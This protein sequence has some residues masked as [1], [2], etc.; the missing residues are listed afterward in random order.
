LKINSVPL[1][2]YLISQPDHDAQREGIKLG[3]FLLINQNKDAQKAFYQSFTALAGKYSTGLSPIAM[4]LADYDA[5]VL[6]CFDLDRKRRLV[7]YKRMLSFLGD[8]CSGQQHANQLLMSKSHLSGNEKSIIDLVVDIFK[9]EYK[10]FCSD[11]SVDIEDSFSRLDLIQEGMDALVDF[12]SGPN[13]ENEKALLGTEIIKYLENWIQI[14]DELRM[15]YLSELNL[16]R[17]ETYRRFTYI[18][19]KTYNMFFDSTTVEQH[20]ILNILDGADELEYSA[21]VLISTLMD[22]S[23]DTTDST[24]NSNN[25]VNSSLLQNNFDSKQVSSSQIISNQDRLNKV[26]PQLNHKWMVQR[27]KVLWASIVFNPSL[28]SKFLDSQRQKNGFK[29]NSDSLWAQTKRAF[30]LLQ[31]VEDILSDNSESAFC[32][33]IINHVSLTD[34]V[35]FWMSNHYTIARKEKNNDIAFT[36][37][38]ILTELVDLNGDKDFIRSC[39]EHL[40]KVLNDVSALWSP[41][42]DQSLITMDESRAFDNYFAS[43]EIILN[44]KLQRV[45]FPVTKA[46][47]DQKRNKIVEV[48]TYYYYYFLFFNLFIYVLFRF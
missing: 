3:Q 14:C 6:S 5:E 29:K 11:T 31:K 40:V 30:S 4:K 38:E 16:P 23:S 43:I 8:F 27:F 21:L 39:E 13:L 2:C 12:I 9:S 26:V 28:L 15:K 19:R 20:N 46:C 35:G 47:R 45:Y 44:G 48:I 32:P 24:K 17:P 42:S 33:D 36:Y 1:V 34:Y 41:T 37:F 10:S 7:D 25:N 22:P 18:C